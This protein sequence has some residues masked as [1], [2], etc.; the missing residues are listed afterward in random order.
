[1]RVESATI[2][3]ARRY[4]PEPYDGRISLFLANEAATRSLDRP[5]AWA[6]YARGG[7]DV[8]CGPADCDGDSMLKDRTAAVFGAQ[9]ALRLDPAWRRAPGVPA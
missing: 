7:L 8:F 6:D 5:L 9:L 4:R 3:A 1:V 2:A